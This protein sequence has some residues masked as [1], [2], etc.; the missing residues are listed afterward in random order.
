MTVKPAKKK[1]ANNSKAPKPATSSSSAR[2]KAM[3]TPKMKPS[4]KGAAA[5]RPPAKSTKIEA[6]PKGSAKASPKPPAPAAGKSAAKAAP[7]PPAKKES[8]PAKAAKTPPGKE[9]PRAAKGS[10]RLAGSAPATALSGKI[11]KA[12]R[13]PPEPRIPE[14]PAVPVKS[15]LTKKELEQFRRLLQNKHGEFT[16]AYR[17]SKGD[18]RT[19]LSNG[20]EDYIDYAVSSYSK[21]FLLSLTEMD[22]RQL[23][24][25]QDALRRIDRGEYGLCLQCGQEIPRKRLEVQPWARHCVR[26]QEL[27][28]Q[29]LLRPV[30][31]GA[32]GDEFAEVPLELGDEEF[33]GTHPIRRVE[34]EEEEEEDDEE[35]EDVE[36]E[37]SEPVESVKIEP[38]VEPLVVDEEEEVEPPTDA[39]EEE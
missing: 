26:C 4:D 14:P 13:K 17:T 19:D 9:P 31:Y 28:E 33:G 6:A 32:E 27:E 25:V 8:K 11:P 34:E 16:V 12:A 36:E 5:V 7:A 37:A 18:S 38:D 1:A 3:V 15:S 10:A 23:Q 39:D 29:G 24:L 35:E 20:T 21:E 30:V 22:R 2:T